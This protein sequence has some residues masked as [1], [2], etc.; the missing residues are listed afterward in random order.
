VQQR[1]QVLPF[2]LTSWLLHFVASCFGRLG[3]TTIGFLA[4][5][6]LSQLE[7]EQHYQ[8]LAAQGLNTIVD[9]DPSVSAQ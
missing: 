8:W 7:L 1:D 2:L 4:V 5:L 3:L 6:A 9:S